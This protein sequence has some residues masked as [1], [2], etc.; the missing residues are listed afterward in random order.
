M[1]RSRFAID[2]DPR[3]EE[4]MLSGAHAFTCMLVARA[5]EP[6][7]A[8]NDA[9]PSPSGMNDPRPPYSLFAFWA[10]GAVF[11]SGGFS[12]DQNVNSR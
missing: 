10:L 9:G 4:D 3:K 6:G 5:P 2:V 8:A 11:F 12:F 7:R 1:Y